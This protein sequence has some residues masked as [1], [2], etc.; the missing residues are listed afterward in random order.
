[1]KPPRVRKR[2]DKYRVIEGDSNKLC[3]NKKGTVMDGGGHKSKAE[4]ERQAG[5]IG[6]KAN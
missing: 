1:M 3:R 4:A 2:D 6:G 5:Y